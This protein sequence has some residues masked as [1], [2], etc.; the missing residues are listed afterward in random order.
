MAK[1]KIGVKLDFTGLLED[2]QRAGGN[3]S[4]AAKQAAEEC[5]KVYEA[6]LRAE[7]NADGIPASITNEIR[8][9]V[10]VESGGNVYAVKVGWEK[11]E[12]DPKNPSAAYK[13]IFLNYGTPKGERTVQEQKRVH[14]ELGGRWVTL[15][16]NRG[17]L[18]A[19][20]FI[21]RAQKNADKK[22]KKV[23]KETLARILKGLK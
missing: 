15:R 11:G 18:V 3:A 2:I 22:V 17:K 4:A 16:K 9:E 23:Q 12:Y 20:G 7:C 10:T 14:H 8:Q 5:A 6:E 21:G 13:A 1:S 19:R